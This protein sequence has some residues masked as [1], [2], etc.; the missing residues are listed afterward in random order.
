MNAISRAARAFGDTINVGVNALTGGY[1]NKGIG[2]LVG[3]SADQVAQADKVR[4]DQLGL[5]GDIAHGIG[6]A[7]LIGRGLKVA[8]AGLSAAKALP[9]AV[10][11]ARTAGPAT[12][13]RFVTGRAGPGLVPV[14]GGTAL[15]PTLKGTAATLAATAPVAASV[16]GGM[17]STV[18]P[19]GSKSA[20][21][22]DDPNHIDLT[23]PVNVALMAGR[24]APVA[25]TPQE[26][27]LSALDT[28]L[29]SPKATLSDLQAVTAMMPA[30]ARRQTDKDAAFGQTAKLSRAIF[31]NQIASI[32]AQKDLGEIT[33]EQA[34]AMTAKAM[35]EEF[36][37]QAGMQGFN[38]MNLLQAQMMAQGEE[39]E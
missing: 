28:I 20:A 15:R 8:G 1:F 27:Q 29:R 36:Q 10:T 5:T 13:L 12:A 34:Q 11:L 6:N 16:I 9:T 30:P 17:D 4:R 25:I 39:A 3:A 22:K 18:T 37:R 33:A 26:R 14:G 35:N 19:Q 32:G 21:W 7:A 2:A 23:N 24:A 38:P 31:D